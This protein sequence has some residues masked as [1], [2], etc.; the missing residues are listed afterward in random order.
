M[1]LHYVLD[2][3]ENEAIVHIEG[4]LTKFDSAY[5]LQLSAH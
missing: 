5:P 2:L 3:G 1:F 4:K